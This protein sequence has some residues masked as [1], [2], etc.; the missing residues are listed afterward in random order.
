MLPGM[1]AAG[2]VAYASAMR[3]TGMTIAIWIIALSGAA[4][5]QPMTGSFRAEATCA[6]PPSIRAPDD[7]PGNVRVMAGESYEL[8]GRNATPGSH[9]LI[10]IPGA[11][12]ERRW[13]AYGCGRVGETS[14]QAAVVDDYVLAASWPSAFCEEQPNA[15]EC[16]AGRS[17]SRFALH[18]LWPQTADGQG[19]CDLPREA[20]ARKESTRWRDLPPTPV[21]N[22]TASELARVMPGV[23]SGL[24]RHQW[25]KHGTCSGMTP[26][27]YFSQAVRL[28]DALNASQVRRLFSGAIGEDL[29]V[30]DIRDAFDRA[31]G[32]G[33][34]QRV[35]VDCNDVQGRTLI[36]ELRISLGG[37]LS[38]EPLGQ[39]IA[40]GNRQPAGC[41]AG[42]VDAPGPARG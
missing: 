5:Q 24:D 11:E 29:S 7:N 37:P 3:I 25:A 33:A 19:Y 6:A 42:E 23:Q 8:L 31:F 28:V 4:A 22:R 13:V 14:Q 30:Q 41:R 32:A 40:R 16:R 9:Y 35:L 2:P 39:L 17:F 34:G 1:A 36:R 27:D 18:G 38:D 10:R 26:D 20:A 15:R 21:G 12:P